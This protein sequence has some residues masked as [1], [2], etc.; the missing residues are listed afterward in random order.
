[1]RYIGRCLGAEKERNEA[2]YYN[3]KKILK[4]LIN[5]LATQKGILPKSRSK[6]EEVEKYLKSA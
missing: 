4:M 5:Y 2:I 6:I 1:M 3:L